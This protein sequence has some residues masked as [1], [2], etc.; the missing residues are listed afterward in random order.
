[1]TIAVTCDMPRHRGPAAASSYEVYSK[2]TGGRVAIDLCD[3]CY[4]KVVAPLMAHGREVVSPRVGSP[5]VAVV[6]HVG[7]R[8]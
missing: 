1:M 7:H 5:R 2:A 3:A 4:A 8:T 6:G